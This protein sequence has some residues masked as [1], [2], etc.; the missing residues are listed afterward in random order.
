[1]KVKNNK[2]LYQDNQHNTTQHITSRTPRFIKDGGGG[3][4]G[5]G[6]GDAWRH[7]DEYRRWIKKM[8]NIYELL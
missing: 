2:I 4:E 7:D 6:G 8:K 5:E 1:V 3:G